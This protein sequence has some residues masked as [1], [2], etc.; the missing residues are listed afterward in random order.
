MAAALPCC[1]SVRRIDVLGAAANGSDYG[2]VA[3]TCGWSP[4]PHRAMP[5]CSAAATSRVVLVEV[6]TAQAA[7]IAAAAS[8]SAVSFALR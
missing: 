8:V 3:A 4:Y 7:A 1:V 2:V 5:A 6:D